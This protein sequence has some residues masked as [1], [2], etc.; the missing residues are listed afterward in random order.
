MGERGA[1]FT[2]HLKT[3][4]QYPLPQHAL[5]RLTYW[6]TRAHTR[7]IKNWLID[8]FVRHFGVD[9][10]EAVQTNPAAY[11]SFNAFFTRALRAEAR[12]IAAEP[13]AVACPADGHISQIGGIEDNFIIQAKD[14]GFTVDALLGDRASAERFAGG[15]FVTLYLS[16]RDYHRVHMPVDGSL[17]HMRHIPGRL[18]SVNP[19]AVRS[20]PGLFA[21]NERVI[22][23]F[24]TA[25]GPMALVLVGALNVGSIETVWAGELTPA[26]GKRVR[27]WSY[28]PGEV[29]LHKGAEAGR[30]NMGST[31]ILLF[32]RGRVLWAPTL[33]E[34]SRVLAGQRL[35]T[36]HPDS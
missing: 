26:C 13:E 29:R 24:E 25:A 16:P 35:G 30:F 34:G 6:L 12:P 15:E 28:K 4:W 20:V 11:P 33:E 17:L 8:A 7:P 27:N 36:L 23:L 10:S 31:V 18:F 2:D 14:R 1:S 5:S 22:N 21:R 19:P 3:L 32:S 9:L